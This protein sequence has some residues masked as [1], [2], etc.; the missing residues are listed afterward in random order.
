LQ[1]HRRDF[2]RAILFALNLNPGITITGPD[3]L[4]G[5]QAPVTIHFGIIVFT[6][7]KTLDRV[8]RIF[9]IGNSL[10][11]R[12]FT[13]KSLTT[14]VHSYNRRSGARAFRIRNYDRLS[15]F[16]DSDTRVSRSQIDSNNLW[17]N[18]LLF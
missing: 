8:D 15:A 7:H 14:F 1:D 6:A 11:F 9:R 5:H 10:T 17:H 13:N 3:N 16:H 2:W 18:C 12:Y 4:I